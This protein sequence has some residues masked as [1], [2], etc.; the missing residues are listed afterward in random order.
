VGAA[1]LSG[2]GG[3]IVTL[4]DTLRSDFAEAFVLAW[5]AKIPTRS[6]P[7]Q[8]TPSLVASYR[9]AGTVYQKMSGADPAEPGAKD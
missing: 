8:I 6:Y 2:S 7:E 4:T 3:K 5:E 9:S 1:A